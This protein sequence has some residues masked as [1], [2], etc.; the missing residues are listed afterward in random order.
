MSIALGIVAFL[1]ILDSLFLVLVVLA[2]KSKDGGM[3]AAIGGGAAEAAFGADTSNVLF[4][5]TKYATVVFFVLAFTLYL[6]RIYERKHASLAAGE[7]LPNIAVPATPA[8][9]ATTPAPAATTPAAAATTA[10]VT[11][12]ASTTPAKTTP[13]TPAPAGTAVPTEP[14]KTP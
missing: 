11:L 7:A 13:A 12:P 2:Q 6:G 14:K 3:G 5:T 10:P 4:N 1:L 8:P 9:T